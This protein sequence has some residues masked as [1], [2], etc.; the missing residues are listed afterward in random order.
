MTGISDPDET[1]CGSMIKT[2]SGKMTREEFAV[3]LRNLSE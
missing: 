2:A 3:I 1:L